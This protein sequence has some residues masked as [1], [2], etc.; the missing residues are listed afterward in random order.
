[1]YKYACSFGLIYKLQIL[2][3]LTNHKNKTAI[4]FLL[5]SDF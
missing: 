2:H 4:V 5:N 3:L 1:M